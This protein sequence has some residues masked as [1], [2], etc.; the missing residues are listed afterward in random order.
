MIVRAA[1]LAIL[2]FIAGPAL[3]MDP[4]EQMPDAAQEAKAEALFSELRCMVCQ[5]QSILD[6]DAPL[7]KDLRI[8]VRERVAAGDGPDAIKDFLVARY[9]DF[10]LLKPR[11]NEQTALLWAVPVLVLVIGGFAVVL[12]FRRRN[13]VADQT[14]SE[15]EKRRLEALKANDAG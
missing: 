7:A 11:L 3:A 13:A 15:D 1:L 9:G 4:G 5:N 8:L 12:N 2:L 10:V 14:L 6:S